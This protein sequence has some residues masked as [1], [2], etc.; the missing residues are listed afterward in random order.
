MP[1][2]SYLIFKEYN[3]L[4]IKDNNENNLA[5]N[6]DNLIILDGMGKH[7]I[8]DKHFVEMK[9]I[10]KEEIKTKINISN[11]DIL[12]YNL[13]ML[14]LKIRFKQDG[15]R[16]RIKNGSKKVN[17]VLTDKKIKASLRNKIRVILDKDDNILAILGVKKSYLLNECS[18]MNLLIKTNYYNN[19]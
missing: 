18:E 9:E 7:N 12:C 10:T 5:S 17:D 14:P 6:S 8:D 16:I 15:D 3:Q 4:I 2:K 13:N 19:L 11:L 1:F